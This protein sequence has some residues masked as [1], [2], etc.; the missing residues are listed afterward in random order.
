[1]TGSAIGSRSRAPRTRGRRTMNRRGASNSLGLR[2][3][4]LPEAVCGPA[5][6]CGDGLEHVSPELV[7]ERP[8]GPVDVNPLE[9][10]EQVVGGDGV[11]AVLFGV[12][13]DDACGA[14]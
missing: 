10:V 14:F 8:R 4:G 1:C 11:L 2:L 5:E 13:L 6:G 9:D 12:R 7:F 3:L